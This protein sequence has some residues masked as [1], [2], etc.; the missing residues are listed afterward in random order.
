MLPHVFNPDRATQPLAVEQSGRPSPLVGLR[1]LDLTDLPG[2]YAGKLLADLGADVVLVEP[3]V[4]A[5]T[6][7][8]GP[9]VDGVTGPDR[10]LTF[11]YLNTSKRG[12]TLELDHPEGPSVLARLTAW[13][14]VL[15][16]GRPPGY[17]DERGLGWARL[18]EINPAL[19]LTSISPFGQIGPA[20]DWL[21]GNLIAQASGGTAALCGFADG[22][23]VRLGGR[24][25]FMVPAQQAAVATM[26]AVIH[27]RR[28]GRGQHVDVSAQEAL[29]FSSQPANHWWTALN[30]VIQRSGNDYV[31]YGSV[32]EAQDGYVGVTTSRA[33][34][35]AR[36]LAW[37]EEE[38]LADDLG[39]PRW[40]DPSQQ[41]AFRRKLKAQF[42]E[43]CKR[44]SKYEIGA[45]AQRRRIW[46]TP[47]N[48][49][50][51]LE[52]D[53]HLIERG[54]FQ[55]LQHEELGQSLRF[56]GP[57]YRM[58]NTPWRLQRQAPRLG[59]HNSDV[60]FAAGF[61]ESELA[62]LAAVGVI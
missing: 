33:D 24:L 3:R 35:N 52:S 45:E 18:H 60:Y 62:S 27:S 36:L 26:L 58:A 50:T 38:G 48:R 40:R 23:P 11:L 37:L 22:P 4:G 31:R 47:V 51:E 39:D 43:L 21:G 46:M 41:H 12:I 20:R 25:G 42:A 1:V 44:R 59:E 13:T 30:D 17:L 32:A 49:T 29:A 7:G 8:L 28:S 57:P 55:P 34:A 14:N 10:S 2:M 54:Y 6:R 53:P 61:V 19:V 9:F 5:A 56:P 16:E 15:I